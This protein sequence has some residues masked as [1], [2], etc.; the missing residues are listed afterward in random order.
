M[1]VVVPAFACSQ[2]RGPPAISGTIPGFKV[3]IAPQVASRVD[4]PSGVKH[5]DHAHEAAP[6]NKG[7]AAGQIKDGEQ[8]QR[9]RDVP[10]VQETVVRLRSQV[11]NVLHPL[12]RVVLKVLVVKQVTDVRVKEALQ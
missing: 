3:A 8:G 9:D 2:E 6:E 5:Q 1:V 12:T 7:Q 10:G 11:G 4:E